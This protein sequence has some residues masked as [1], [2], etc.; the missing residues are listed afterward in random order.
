MN[1]IDRIDK[2]L[3]EWNRNSPSKP[4]HPALPGWAFASEDTKEWKYEAVYTRRYHG[5]DLTILERDGQWIPIHGGTEMKP[6]HDAKSASRI[7]MK[8]VDDLPDDYKW[9]EA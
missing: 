7:L 6:M 2:H 9:K 1:I 8:Y 4:R 5:Y 3:V